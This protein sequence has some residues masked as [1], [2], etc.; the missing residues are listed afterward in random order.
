MNFN[1]LDA[2]LV[3]RCAK[4]RKIAN[5]TYAQRRGDDAIAIRFH[6]TDVV[7]FGRDGRITLDTGGYSTMS[8]K[9][10]INDAIE[11]YSIFS[12]KG[13]WMVSRGNVRNPDAVTVPFADGMVISPNGAI[14][15]VDF[16]AIQRQDQRNA[17]I[18]KKVKKYCE[19]LTPEKIVE[20]IENAGGDCFLCLGG[21]SFGGTEHL[22]SHL[23][24][25][26]YMAH[27]FLNVL[28]SR[29]YTNADFIMS[30]IYNDAK[31]GKVWYDLRRQ[32]SKYFR[33]AL[34]EGAVAVA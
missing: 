17:V 29:G 33:K 8:T 15:G 27:L 10:R 19:N 5:N 12:V 30:M 11:G 7:V 26:Y 20:A 6:A 24:E 18:S 32:L 22:E 23:D 28:K 14:S 3:G 16:V 2:K 13:R 1:T 25:G 34:I 21:N 9:A 4:G 31:N